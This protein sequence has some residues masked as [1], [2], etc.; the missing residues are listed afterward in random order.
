MHKNAMGAHMASV[1][2]QKQGKFW[3]FHD[4]LF[5]EQKQLNLEAYRRHASEL[6]LDVAQFERD[7]AD[8]ENQ[9]RIDA[10]KAEAKSL[11]ITGTPGFFVNGRFL[12]GAKPFEDFAT[13]INAELARQNIPLPPEAPTG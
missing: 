4:R 9:R 11:G 12:R 5:E 1:A 10:D 8:L 6:G 2:A 7:L 13:L 3:E